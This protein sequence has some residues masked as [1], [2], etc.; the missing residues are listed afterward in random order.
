MQ[1]ILSFRELLLGEYT[2]QLISVDLMVADC[3]T[4]L[5]MYRQK[6]ADQVFNMSGEFGHCSESFNV[7]G[8][9]P[10]G[11][12]INLSYTQNFD[13]GWFITKNAVGGH[14]DRDTGIRKSKH[15]PPPDQDLPGHGADGSVL[16]L[17]SSDVCKVNNTDKCWWLLMR[18][19]IQFKSPV[20]KALGSEPNQLFTR[21]LCFSFGFLMIFPHWYTIWNNIERMPAD[22]AVT[23]NKN[24]FCSLFTD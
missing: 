8:Y 18:I 6:L 21:I 22:I 19:R 13:F 5:S 23:W 12:R 4:P 1:C 3:N 20:F 7:L 16:G 24:I 2:W 10:R 11:C 15:P 9:L 17:L 14:V